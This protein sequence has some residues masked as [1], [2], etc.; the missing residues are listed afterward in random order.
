VGMVPYPDAPALYAAAD[1]VAIPQLDEEAARHQMPLK[2]VDAMAMGRPIVASAVS[3]LPEVLDGCGRVV[4]PGD[5]FALTAAI[6]DLLDDRPQ[7]D[8]LGANARA[9]CLERYSFERIGAQLAAIVGGLAPAPA[10]TG[11]G[12]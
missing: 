2:A 10:T 6:R 9:R 12:R 3:D 11:A 8:E 5:A 4:P 1:V 7:A